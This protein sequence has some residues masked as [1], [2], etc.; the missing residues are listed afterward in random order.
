[1]LFLDL[2]GIVTA[3]LAAWFWY[4]AG[5]R[6]LRRI[7]K[8]EDLDAA[9]INRIVIAI[10]RSNLLNARAA[11]AAAA[12]AASLAARFVADLVERL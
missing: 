4:L 12:S 8:F 5:R 1:M 6:R 9:D 10:N 7:S 2:F 11:L 3:L